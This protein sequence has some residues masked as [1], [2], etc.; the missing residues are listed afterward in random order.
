VPSQPERLSYP[1]EA[2]Y[3]IADEIREEG[4]TVDILRIDHR[5]TAYRD[6]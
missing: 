5:P 1:A 2:S 4:S 6:R 3:R